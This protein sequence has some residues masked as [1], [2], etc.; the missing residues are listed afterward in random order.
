V[1]YKAFASSHDDYVAWLD[2]IKHTHQ[3]DIWVRVMGLDHDHV[4]TVTG[5]VLDGQ[6]TIDVERE[7]TRVAN[8]TLFD[9]TRSLAWEPDSAADLPTHRRR[10]IQILD[11]R[12]VPGIGWMPCPVFTGPVVDFDRDGAQVSIVAEGKERMALGNFGTNHSWS[13]KR[14]V[15]DVIRELLKIA[16]EDSARIHLPDLNATLPEKLNVTRTDSPWLH[17]KKLARV[18]NRVLFYDGRGHVV[19]RR[20]P[21]TPALTIGSDSLLS[22]VRIDREQVE[23]KNRWIV[24]GPKPKGN[25]RRVH[26]DITLPRSHPMSPWSLGRNGVPHWLIDQSVHE[27]LKTNAKAREIAL[28]LRDEQM[29]ASA[30]LAFDCLPFPNVEEHDLLRAVD[31]L[32]G[33]AVVRARQVTIPLVEGPM[34]V[35]QL[36]RVSIVKGAKR[37]RYHWKGI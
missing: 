23:F 22:H 16:G 27:Q 4:A 25:K 28:D 24:Y 20:L 34:T 3:R 6:V 8:L 14:R 13:S 5:P 21:K 11:R 30:P 18:V 15:T 26:A 36:K 37:D 19:M 7:V 29:R 17:A 31:P 35:G 10:M 1:A 12:L 32:M 9:R 2:T 33:A